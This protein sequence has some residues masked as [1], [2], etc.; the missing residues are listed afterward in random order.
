[1]FFKKR[2]AILSKNLLNFFSFNKFLT[3]IL[4][5]NKTIKYKDIYDIINDVFFDLK[6]LKL[7]LEKA[8]RVIFQ[9]N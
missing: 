6:N 7:V 8:N 3:H 5:A 9:T 2:I 1:M 4:E